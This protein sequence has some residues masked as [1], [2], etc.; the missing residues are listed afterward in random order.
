MTV[1][2][3]QR[4]HIQHQLTYRV[5]NS[6]N[7]TNPIIIKNCR[8]IKDDIK[9]LALISIPIGRA[10]LIPA[11]FQIV[12]KRFQRQQVFPQ[13]KGTL[14]QSQQEIA[15]SIYDNAIVGAKPGW[16]KA[17]PRDSKIRVPQGWTTMQDIRVGDTVMSPSG[18]RARVVNKYSHFDKP[19]YKLTLQDG[20]QVR[21][22]QDHLWL[23]IDRNKRQRVLSTKQIIQ[24][25]YFKAK[26]LYLPLC[27][28]IQDSP[29]QHIIHPYLLGIILGDGGITATSVVISSADKQV[30]DTV[31]QL[32]PQGCSIKYID[33]YDYRI[34][35]TDNVNVII[36]QLKRLGLMGCNSQTKFIP[37]QYLFDSLQNKY[38]LLQGFLDSDGTVDKVG[39]KIQYYSVSKR[40]SQGFSQLIF[41]L[42]G[43]CSVRAKLT[44]YSYKGQNRQGKPCF[45]MSP[46]R[47]P[48]QK[49]K[50]LF[51]LNRKKDLVI[52]GQYDNSNKV[53]IQSIQY[54]NN[55]D[56]W[57]I[58]LDSQDK[59]YLTDN[60]VVTH[61]TFWAIYHA[62]QVLKQKTLIVVHTVA[63]RMQWQR[64]II[65]TLGIKPGVIG[66]GKFNID[67]PIVVANVQSLVNNIPQT[68]RQ[69]GALYLDQM[70]HVSSPTFSKIIDTSFARYKI[71]LSGTLNRKD[72]KHVVFRDYF[73]SDVRLP[74][75]QNV[76]QPQVHV[77]RSFMQ[78][79]SGDNW[80]QRASA[81]QA[82]PLYR[83]LL[84]GLAD[85][86]SQQG[87]KVLITSD[88]VQTLKYCSDNSKRPSG[89]VIGG[90]DRQ[91]VHQLLVA[92]EIQQL[93]GTQSIYCQGISLD[94][95]SCLIL[96]GM[97]N[98]Q[99]LLQQ[100]AGRIRRMYKNKL[101][102]VIVD[103]RM[104][105]YT[106]S[107]Q[108]NT[109]MGYYMRNNFKVKYLN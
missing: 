47:L 64:Q 27:N 71:G 30:I 69:F 100:L 52:A 94:M 91:K 75:Q 98:N 19:I 39:N 9:G 20:R 86:Y 109:R 23:T 74:Q 46:Q 73:S 41:S 76:M 3:R 85:K 55:Q 51:K 6:H 1:D 90:Q 59:L 106:G 81:I 72:G 15:D 83:Q 5:P 7:P 54:E 65:K 96:G 26:R 102:P 57:C 37:Q 16:G 2:R 10:D 40:L 29:K 12:D 88:R 48:L 21:A 93:F 60:Y 80:A 68:N 31:R 99:P 53:R 8:T 63:L 14:R 78:I 67:A 43:S 49:K 34:V 28:S 66:S 79:P 104:D 58:S 61:N 33:N 77:Y 32:L 4:Q 101:P 82:H 108:F 25:S 38:S 84:L 105:G 92:G 13:F 24:D 17:Q 107:K 89:Y 103:I 62:S 35:G 50:K 97:V 44:N 95:L 42:G 70:H 11:G 18:G 22:C 87:H 56:C 45:V 36:T